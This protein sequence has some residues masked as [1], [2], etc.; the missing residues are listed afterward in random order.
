MRRGVA[1]NHSPSTALRGPLMTP[2]RLLLRRLLYVTEGKANLPVPLRRVIPVAGDQGLKVGAPH[3]VLL[4]TDAPILGIRPSDL[5]LEPSVSFP[6]QL[7]DAFQYLRH[8]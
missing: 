7:S 5:I 6:L 1:V 2:V 8:F 4:P 3:Y